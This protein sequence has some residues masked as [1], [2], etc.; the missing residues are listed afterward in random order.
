MNFK[1]YITSKNTFDFP[2]VWERKCLYKY[3][4]AHVFCL[5]NGLWAITEQTVRLLCLDCLFNTS[6]FKYF[7]CVGLW[8]KKKESSQKWNLAVCFSEGEL[9]TGWNI[10]LQQMV[11][12]SYTTAIPF[13]CL[14]LK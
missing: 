1:L 3:M 10:L 2:V 13:Q 6:K 8:Q 7:V 11:V 9:L 12:F 5:Q 14:E 4:L